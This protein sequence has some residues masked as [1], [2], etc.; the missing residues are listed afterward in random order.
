MVAIKIAFTQA[1]EVLAAAEHFGIFQAAQKRACVCNRL[2]GIGRGCAAGKHRAR[3]L[4]SKI[5]NRSKVRVEAQRA[6]FQAQDFSVHAEELAVA[7][8]K[9]LLYGWRRRDYFF[10]AI[11]GAA[12]QID[13]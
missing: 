3:S 10:Q 9:Y 11:N 1:R 13:A 8:G 2:F 6:R 4:E 5:E 12:F 7:G